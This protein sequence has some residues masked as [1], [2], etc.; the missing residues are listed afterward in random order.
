MHCCQCL[1]IVHSWL[2]LWFSLI[3]IYIKVALLFH[4]YFFLFFY[5]VVVFFFV[6]GKWCNY[7]LIRDQ[8][9]V[10]LIGSVILTELFLFNWR[11]E[12]RKKGNTEALYFWPDRNKYVSIKSQPF[13]HK[14]ISKWLVP[15][16]ASRVAVKSA[17]TLFVVTLLLVVVT[18]VNCYHMTT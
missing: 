15:Y 7:G 9:F 12:Y 5:F 4:W 17:K 8:P 13:S 1:W 18:V 10:L 6:F 11:Q 16:I 3:F 14:M 2:P